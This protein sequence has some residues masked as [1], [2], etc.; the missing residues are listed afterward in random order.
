MNHQLHSA[1][2][3]LAQLILALLAVGMLALSSH[4]KH[5]Q[6]PQ[7]KPQ[8]TTQLHSSAAAASRR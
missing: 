3:A 2:K 5:H 1:N 7:V 8:P 6:Q 4:D